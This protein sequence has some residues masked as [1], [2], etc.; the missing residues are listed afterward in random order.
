MSLM[1]SLCNKKLYFLLTWTN[2]LYSKIRFGSS[3]IQ[4]DITPGTIA[5]FLVIHL[6]W[7]RQI[8]TTQ[9][10]KKEKEKSGVQAIK[11]GPL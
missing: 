3:K 2:A 9:E 7:T 1:H 8:S 10:R 5:L 11:I 4:K 6:E